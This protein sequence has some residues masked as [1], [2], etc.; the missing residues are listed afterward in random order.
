MWKDVIDLG[1]VVETTVH[2]ETLQTMVY[3][4]VFANKKSV[5][6]SEFYNAANVGLKPELI[7]EVNSFEFTNDEKVNT[8]IRNSIIRPMKKKP[9]N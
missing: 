1:N 8:T 3:R 6:Q 2:G 9:P 5:R 7:F 4:T